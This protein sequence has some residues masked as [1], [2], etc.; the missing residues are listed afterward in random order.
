M[1]MAYILERTQN[2][3]SISPLSLMPICSAAGQGG[4]PGMVM[5]S[6]HITITKP[7]PAARRTSRIGTT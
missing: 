3:P 2:R 1:T 4:R 5:I 7:A 6:P